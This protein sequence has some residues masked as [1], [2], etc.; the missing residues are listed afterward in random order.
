M[1]WCAIKN[2]GKKTVLFIGYVFGI[3]TIIRY[4]V[5]PAF[6]WFA[7]L[8][9]P[10]YYRTD[11]FGAYFLTI[12]LIGFS[13]VFILGLFGLVIPL[14]VECIKDWYKTEVALCE[15]KKRVKK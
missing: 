2:M 5:W 13:I 14:V 9:D 1:N 12:A 7:K 8:V 10:D 4:A 15:V 3:L 11:R 6:D